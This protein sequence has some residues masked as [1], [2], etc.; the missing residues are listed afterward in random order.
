[1]NHFQYIVAQGGTARKRLGNTSLR[2][3]KESF[4]TKYVT[5]PQDGNLLT[6][7]TNSIDVGTKT[8]FQ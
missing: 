1:M 7:F 5:F 4:D 8:L 2:H 3:M 6:A